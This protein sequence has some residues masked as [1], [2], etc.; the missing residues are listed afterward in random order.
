MLTCGQGDD[1]PVFRLGIDTSAEERISVV[2]GGH[3]RLFDGSWAHPTQEV[4]VGASFVV[5]A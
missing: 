2:G 5:G 4:E 1:W 3:Q